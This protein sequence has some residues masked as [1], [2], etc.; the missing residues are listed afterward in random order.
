MSYLAVVFVSFS[1]GLLVTVLIERPASILGR[2]YERWLA[3][4]MQA[5]QSQSQMK[6]KMSSE[7]L[8]RRE[9]ESRRDQYTGRGTPVTVESGT[10][11]Q[12]SGSCS[13]AYATEV[14]SGLSASFS[15]GDIN[16]T[17]DRQPLSSHSNDPSHI[18]QA[19]VEPPSRPA[20]VAVAQSP[21]EVAHRSFRQA[22]YSKLPPTECTSLL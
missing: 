19:T 9:Q 17:A 18:V 14:S 2:A 16:M 3:E 15:N 5:S 20:A 22:T 21:R 4:K 1:C 10:N 6:M 13:S 8:G 7:N 12:S 11:G